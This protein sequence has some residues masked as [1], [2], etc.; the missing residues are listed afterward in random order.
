MLLSNWLCT[1]T[2]IPQITKEEVETNI[3]SADDL[4]P[5][6]T[7][8]L[9]VNQECITVHQNVISVRLGVNELDK[10][11]EFEPV[12][13]IDPCSPSTVKVCTEV[14]LVIVKGPFG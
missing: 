14:A 3:R 5:Y 4:P 13:A 6:I 10:A 2:T 11:Y 9:K 7:F 12:I 1:S 8:Q